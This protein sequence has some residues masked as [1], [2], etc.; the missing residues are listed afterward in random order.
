LDKRLVRRIVVIQWKCPNNY[1]VKIQTLNGLDLVAAA[2]HTLLF[3]KLNS[4][5]NSHISCNLFQLQQQLN[6][7]IWA[8][9][10][11]RNKIYYTLIE[12]HT[13][14]RKNAAKT[15]SLLHD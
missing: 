3:P 9:E 10:N 11:D 4:T 2:D 1:T 8:K 14:W 5:S 13:K 12:R 15:H 6:L 7:T